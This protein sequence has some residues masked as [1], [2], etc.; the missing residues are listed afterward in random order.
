MGMS[1]FEIL[2]KVEMPLAIPTIMRRHPR[3][4]DRDRRHGDDRAAGGVVTLG[5]FILDENVY[6]DNGVLAGAMV[7][8]LLALDLRVR[9]RQG[10]SACSPPRA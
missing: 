1:E 8:A 6:G 5:D 10:C 2:R 4:R 9:A 3:R 7:V